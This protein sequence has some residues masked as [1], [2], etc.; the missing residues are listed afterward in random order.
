MGGPDRSPR[1]IHLSAIRKLPSISLAVPP[2]NS[3]KASTSPS[4]AAGLPYAGN[5]GAIR[6]TLEGAP[7]QK[8]DLATYTPMV[9]ESIPAIRLRPSV[10]RILS[11]DGLEAAM[12]DWDPDALKAYVALLGLHVIEEHGQDAE[13]ALR[14]KVHIWQQIDDV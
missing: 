7:S 5:Q 14:P 10:G 3:K 2:V 9:Q 13:A 8:S 1:Y 12:R 11:V 4:F 6:V